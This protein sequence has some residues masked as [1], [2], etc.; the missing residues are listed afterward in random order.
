MLLD[1]CKLI[2]VTALKD[3]SKGDKGEKGQR[4]DWWW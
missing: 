1:I 4:E 3:I 2:A